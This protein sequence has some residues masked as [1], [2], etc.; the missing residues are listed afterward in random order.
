[1]AELHSADMEL[2][3]PT[4]PPTSMPDDENGKTSS[5]GTSLVGD[6]EATVLSS[7]REWMDPARE[8]I[9]ILKRAEESE[10]TIL[11]GPL[12]GWVGKFD[13][14][15]LEKEVEAY[16]GWLEKFERE[17][18]KWRRVFAHNDARE[19]FSLS[20]FFFKNVHDELADC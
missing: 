4:P 13:I 18:K 16:K 10:G 20:F 12:E 3:A 19:F 7:I 6:R 2:L 5:R 11:E 8:I 15:A 1:M 14:D 9:E 17:E